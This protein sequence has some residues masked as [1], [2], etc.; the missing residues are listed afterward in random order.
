MPMAQFEGILC[1]VDRRL[2]LYTMVKESSYDQRSVT[3]LDSETF[4]SG[5]QV[6][7]YFV[8]ILLINILLWNYLQ[9]ERNFTVLVFSRATY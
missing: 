8:R 7:L 6:N 9:L 4:L 2:E 5:F 1:N 3:S